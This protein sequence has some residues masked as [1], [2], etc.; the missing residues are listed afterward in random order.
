MKQK[1]IYIDESNELVAGLRYFAEDAG[2]EL[3]HYENVD[4][5]LRSTKTLLKHSVA[6]LLDLDMPDEHEPGLK[7]LVRINASFPNVPIVVM[8]SKGFKYDIDFK[9]D[10]LRHGATLLID[11]TKTNAENLVAEIKYLLKPSNEYTVT[12]P[13]ETEDVD[14]PENF[15]IFFSETGKK[16][17][18]FHKA[19]FG[20]VLSALALPKSDAEKDY[21]LKRSREYYHNIID[22]M[23]YTPYRI[24]SMHLRITKLKGNTEKESGI[25]VVIY[26]TAEYPNQ[27]YLL[28]IASGLTQDLQYS[29]N[30]CSD[31]MPDVFSFSPITDENEINKFTSYPSEFHHWLVV[32]QH[33]T[34]THPKTG[35]RIPFLPQTPETWHDPDMIYKVLL[36]ADYEIS[37]DL[38]LRHFNFLPNEL[39]A[40]QITVNSSEQENQPIYKSRKKQCADL[41]AEGSHARCV[42]LIL[43][44]EKLLPM[45]SLKGAIKYALFN[46]RS[47]HFI[48]RSADS[49]N[50]FKVENG[51]GS[52]IFPFVYTRSQL[53]MVFWWPLPSYQ[54]VPGLQRLPF[55]FSYYPQK[56]PKQGIALGAKSTL[57][58]EIPVN[59]AEG[60]LAQHLY[61]VGQTGTGKST[62][63]KTIFNQLASGKEGICLIDPHGDLAEAALQL[64]PDNRQQ[65]V[66]LFDVASPDCPLL[67][68]LEYDTNFPEQ[69][70]VLVEEL[71]YFMMQNYDMRIAGGPS[72]ETYFR[73]CLEALYDEG[74]QEQFSFPVLS[75][76]ERFFYD[77]GY[78]KAL[79]ASLKNTEVKAFWRNAIESTG[80]QSFVNWGPYVTGKINRLIRNEV[81]RPII[82]QRKPSTISFTDIIAKRKILIVKLDKG[83]IGSANVGMLGFF[84]LNRIIMTAMSQG[85]LPHEKRKRFTMMVDEFQ[86]FTSPTLGMALSEVRKYKLQLVLANQTISQLEQKVASGVLGNVGS[87]ISFRLSPGDAAH[88]TPMLNEYFTANDLVSLPNY[89]CIGHLLNN[90]VLCRPFVFQT[91]K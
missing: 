67:N 6:I 29:F 37:I 56:L 65:D 72:F 1:L 36:N 86:N 24:F 19:T 81:L 57:H 30:R 40:L 18:K 44:S 8:S 90:G 83:K 5:T 39:E 28:K 43:S 13:I 59:I 79:L 52:S 60:D 76:I 54:I 63:L 7:H 55:N 17:E 20:F 91:I 84:L 3:L 74:A 42:S 11:R 15:T 66:V 32:P 27:E 35:G 62:M 50:R 21:C 85:A 12:T 26:F 47:C 46:E 23:N 34:F 68:L 9:N 22:V 2:M 77:D 51:N 49:L 71:F 69:K 16:K 25:R 58:H 89:H 82:S 33:D 61:I 4:E 75:D 31:E 38:E 64:I 45:A 41:L 10:L 80:E 53:S 14:V 48:P 78:R 88:L 73:N 87:R 70:E